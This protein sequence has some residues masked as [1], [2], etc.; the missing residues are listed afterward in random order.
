ML[1]RVVECWLCARTL[2]GGQWQVAS[3]SAGSKY[4]GR[5]R[6]FQAALCVCAPGV[7]RPDS[8]RPVPTAPCSVLDACAKA[9]QPAVVEMLMQA[10]EWGRL[11]ACKADAPLS[12]VHTA[13]SLCGTHVHAPPAA[14]SLHLRDPSCPVCHALCAACAG[15]GGSG[16]SGRQREPHNPAH[17]PRKGERWIGRGRCCC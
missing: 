13:Q 15:D 1:G 9:G 3:T 6:L 12:R 14:P 17:V 16:F 11:G 10:R 5:W 4:I 2:Q 8:S 7:E